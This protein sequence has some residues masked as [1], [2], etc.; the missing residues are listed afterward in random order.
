MV[1]LA[2]LSWMFHVHMWNL[3]VPLTC[4]LQKWSISTHLNCNLSSLTLLFFAKCSIKSMQEELMEVF[5]FFFFFF[6]LIYSFSSS[7]R[8]FYRG[9]FTN[10]TYLI[11]F[12]F[13]GG[14]QVAIMIFA[15]KTFTVVPFPGINKNLWIASVGIA[16]IEIP[17]GISFFL[18]FLFFLSTNTK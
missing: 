7:E 5:F 18:S 16:A 8:S 15:G 14:M 3:R 4:A 13:I 17:L 2:F 6:F 9:L 12:L 10:A 11:V 1:V